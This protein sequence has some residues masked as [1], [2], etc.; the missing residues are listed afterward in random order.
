M[1]MNTSDRGV[2]RQFRLA[3][4][5]SNRILKQVS[6]CFN[7]RVINVSAGEDCDKEGSIYAQYFVNAD[8]YF[9]TNYGL[10]TYRGFRSRSNEYELDLESEVPESLVQQ[11]D[12]V[13][14]HTTLEHIF[15]VRTAFRNLCRLS[16]DVV[17]VVVPFAQV[18]HESDDFGDFWRFTPTC[19]RRLLLE[20]DMT[21]VFEAE[22]PDMD[23]AVYLLV[24]GSRF[25]DRW[26]ERLPPY[27]PIE[28]AAKWIG[29]PEEET[30]GLFGRFTKSFRRFVKS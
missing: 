28:K 24:I 20:N 7:G 15:E 29:R 1:Q 25:P 17:I 26:T 27:K 9:T 11:F 30:P 12:V 13:L 21:V 2:D 3:R 8:E 23:A 4:H 22:S 19:L 5:W 14:N 16:K 10:G 6:K 18:Q